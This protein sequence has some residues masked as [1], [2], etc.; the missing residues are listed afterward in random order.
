MEEGWSSLRGWADQLIARACLDDLKVLRDLSDDGNTNKAYWAVQTANNIAIAALKQA[1]Y[2]ADWLKAE[3]KRSEEEE[4]QVTQ[5]NTLGRQQALANACTHGGQFHASGG[6]TH[7]TCDKIFIAAEISSWRKDKD[8]AELEKKHRL[9]LQAA[10]EKALAIVEQGKSVDKLTFGNSNAFLDWHQVK[11]PQKSKK[12][13]KLGQ[14]MQILA[15]G[16][17]PPEYQRWTD[18]DEQRLLALLTSK[19]G[20][21]DTCYGHELKCCK[22]ELEAAID[23]MSRDNGIAMRRRFDEMDARK[24]LQHLTKLVSKRQCN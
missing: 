22:R 17:Q 18:V 6:G 9:Q 20:L 13:D 14:W 2:D 16:R 7:L 15:E 1:G 21:T 12:D 5:P 3:F 19:I 24:H 10:E 8:E 4:H 11:M 23:H